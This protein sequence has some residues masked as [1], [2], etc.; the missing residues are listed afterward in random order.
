M[1]QNEMFH[2]ENHCVSEMREIFCIKLCSFVLN[3]TVP[4][5]T[6][7][8]CINLAYAKAT[9]TK[10]SGTNFATVPKIGY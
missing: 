10:T 9:K 3:K 2:H 8:C 5:C 4:R 6:V 7:L 1:I